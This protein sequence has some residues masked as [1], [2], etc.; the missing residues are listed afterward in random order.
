LRGLDPTRSFGNQRVALGPIM[1]VAGV[2]S[3]PITIAQDDQTEAVL[4]DLVNPV[5][6]RRD[7]C[8]AR[9]DAGA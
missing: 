7:L 4:L 1:A 5:G 3:N 6:V 2:Q 9:W 8:P